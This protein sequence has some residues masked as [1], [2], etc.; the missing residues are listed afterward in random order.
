MG[1]LTD[2]EKFSGVAW[3]LQLTAGIYDYLPKT[4]K[5][6]PKAPKK[7]AFEIMRGKAE[8]SG[9]IERTRS[10]SFDINA[11]E[12]STV[13]L[14]TL[15]FPGWKVWVDGKETEISIPEEEKWGRMWIEVP[16]GN[17]KIEAKFTNTP[18]R[19]FSNI[20]SL[21]SWGILLVLFAKKI[22]PSAKT[23]V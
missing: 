23:F 8:V 6:A 14:N 10:V 18:I 7:T 4:A 9:I 3:D 19:T 16:S 11:E 5:E 22:K 15:M 13:R 2:E 12:N 21:V 20:I 1:K 17:H